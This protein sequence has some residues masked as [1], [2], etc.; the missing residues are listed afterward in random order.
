MTLGIR[1]PIIDRMSIER[2]DSEVKLGDFKDKASFS[3][4]YLVKCDKDCSTDTILDTEIQRKIAS[5]DDFCIRVEKHVAYIEKPL[6][7]G[8][9]DCKGFYSHIDTAVD[10]IERIEQDENKD[11]SHQ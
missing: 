1:N 3:E 10:I 7:N 2:K 5:L 9:F 4:K 11:I 8:K 6:N